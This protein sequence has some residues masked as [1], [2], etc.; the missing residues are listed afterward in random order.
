M[1][2]HYFYYTSMCYCQTIVF[3]KLKDSCCLTPPELDDI[4]ENHQDIT[5]VFQ[6]SYETKRRPY[7]WDILLMILRLPAVNETELSDQLEI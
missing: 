1:K 7:T 6:L 2:G 3:I 4:E 5:G